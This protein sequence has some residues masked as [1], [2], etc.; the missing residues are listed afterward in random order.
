M[1]RYTLDLGM[2]FVIGT[3]V[4]SIAIRFVSR[5][6]RCYFQLIPRCVGYHRRRAELNM[7]AATERVCLRGAGDERVKIRLV[8]SSVASE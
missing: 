3:P 5:L 6:N 1:I 8:H 2:I 4:L 7:A